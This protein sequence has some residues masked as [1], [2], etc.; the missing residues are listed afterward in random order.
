MME[1]K[2]LAENNFLN[3]GGVFSIRKN[4]KDVIHSLQYA[5]GLLKNTENMVALFPQARFESNYQQPLHFEKG[6]SWILKKLRGK[7]QM[8]FVANQVE[9]F[10]S[11]KPLLFIHFEEYNYSGKT[12]SDIEKDYNL[13]FER[14]YRKNP[15]LKNN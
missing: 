13:F 8:I 3:K 12:F 14:C 1:E 6:L 9:Y 2:Q 5:L 7:V 4:S 11:A 15:T 10:E